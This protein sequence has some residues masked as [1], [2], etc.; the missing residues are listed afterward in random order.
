M[1]SCVVDRTCLHF[2][3]DLGSGDVGSQARDK[4]GRTEN[5]RDSQIHLRMPINLLQL[6][7]GSGREREEVGRRGGGRT[8]DDR[9]WVWDRN[10][11]GGNGGGVGG[12]D[13]VRKMKPEKVIKMERGWLGRGWRR[14]GRHNAV[15]DVGP[16]WV[17]W[18]RRRRRL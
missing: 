4:Y 12:E 5:R 7:W 17:E 13:G 14:R 16:R 2:C 1:Y 10:I 11:G 9:W 18:W 3:T 15:R 6:D 8:T